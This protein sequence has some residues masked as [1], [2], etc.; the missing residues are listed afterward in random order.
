MET[1]PSIESL[2][3]I[4]EECKEFREKGK[5]NLRVRKSYGKDQIRYLRCSRCSSEFSERKGTALF[6]SKIAESK[7]VSVIEHLDSRC[8]VNA[9]ARLVKVSKDSVSRLSRITGRVFNSL[10]DVMVKDTHPKALQFDEKWA[11]TEKKQKNL[12]S[13]DDPTEVGDHWD[14]NCIDPQSK[15]LLTLVPGPRTSESI[16]AAVADAA[17]RLAK[18]AARPAIFT[19]G[20][21]AYEE[22]I[23]E[24]FGNSYPPLRTSNLGRPPLPILRV[25]HDLVYAQVIKH[26]SGGKVCEVEIRP[27]FGKG[28]LDEVVESLGWNKANTSAIERFNLTDRSRNAR[29]AR[30]SLNFSKK[31]RLHDAMSFISVVLYNFHHEHRSLQIK[32]EDGRW[33][34]RTPAMAAGLT[35]KKYS[36]L[37]LLRLSPFQI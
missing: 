25:P 27:I 2:C 33:Q 30:K 37:E 1:R 22:A 17:A 28:K 19:D 4:N 26:R 12:T 24:V 16:K 13:S 14:V 3:C 15:L 31:S 7:A 10:H 6:N 23:L 35:N 5:G 21:P 18:D 29:K 11:F 9:T 20:E 32:D 34:K 36:V 8:G